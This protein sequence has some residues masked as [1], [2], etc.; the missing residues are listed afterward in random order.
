[1]DGGSPTR[2]DV[3]SDAEVL[4]KCP[5]LDTVEAIMETAKMIPVMEDA[6]Q[7]IEVLGRELSE[8]V[9]GNK[10][11]QEALDTLAAEMEDMK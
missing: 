1:M 5:Y 11:P 8:A 4:A 2:S 6:P 9:T 7:L 3:M 10:T